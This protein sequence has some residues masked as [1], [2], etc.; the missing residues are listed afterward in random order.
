ML[1]RTF[2]GAIYI[3]IIEINNAAGIAAPTANIIAWYYE[4]R[5]WLLLLKNISHTV[6]IYTCMLMYPD[7]APATVAT[8]PVCV[9]DRKGVCLCDLFINADPV[10]D[11]CP[12]SHDRSLVNSPFPDFR[13]GV[14]CCILEPETRSSNKQ[15]GMLA[16]SATACAMCY[17]YQ[18]NHVAPVLVHYQS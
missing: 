5:P 4:C 3:N 6:E 11:S 13:L 12:L 8:E 10:S 1:G 18:L 17:L 7:F 15:V 14:L 2:V 9:V 16:P